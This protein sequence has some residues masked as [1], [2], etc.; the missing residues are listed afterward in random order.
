MNILT[1]K[2]RFI[3]ELAKDP[4]CISIMPD[5][6]DIKIY[7]LIS[8]INIAMTL[9]ILKAKLSLKSVPEYDKECKKIQIKAR[10]LK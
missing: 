1:L 8:A 5:E 6:L 4:P 9:A 2:K 7:S 3:K 10:K